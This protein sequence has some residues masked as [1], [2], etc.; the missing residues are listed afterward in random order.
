MNSARERL[1]GYHIYSG[2]INECVD[3]VTN[4]VRTG[5]HARWLACINPHSFVEAT[6]R[7]EFRE[8]IAKADWLIPDGVGIV[9]ASWLLRGKIRRR[10]T[11]SDIFLH[12]HKTLN[13]NGGGRVFLLGAT[14]QTLEAMQRRM[15]R[16]FPRIEV[17]GTMSPPFC[18]E[19]DDA[20]N[21]SMLTAINSANADVLWVGLSAPKQELW[22]YRNCDKLDVKFAAA[23]GAV[24]DFY[25]GKVKRSNAVFQSAGL[26]WLPR[27]LREPRRLWRRMFISAPK[28]IG[29]V[30]NELT[31]ERPADRGSSSDNRN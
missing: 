25:S 30:L 3:S 16:E 7:N 5:D 24:F 20:V 2:S 15:G 13:D 10:L 11:G 1:L 27:L 18:E 17:V 14:A 9:V 19:F 12:L 4:W 29:A 23:V 6:R 31:R 8:A 28:F 21:R 22:I 26:E